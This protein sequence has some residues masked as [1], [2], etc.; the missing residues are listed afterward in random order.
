[1]GVSFFRSHALANA[2]EACVVA[3]QLENA[4]DFAGQ[5]LTLAHERGE[6]GDQAYALRLL[7]EIASHRDP[8]EVETAEEHYR[9]A[10]GLAE[11]LGMRPLIAHCHLG[12]GT[13]YRQTGDQA[14]VAEHWAAARARYREMGMSFWLEKAEAALGPPYRN[15]I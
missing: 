4:R 2:G 10:M 9:Q 3:G 6:R 11:E 13:L 7:G 15:P 12:L 8:A 1:M 5:A 14:K